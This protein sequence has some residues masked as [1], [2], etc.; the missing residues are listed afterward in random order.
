MDV[1][2]PEDTKNIMLH[3]NSLFGKPF[4]H[5]TRPKE[6]N[7]KLFSLIYDPQ[8]LCALKCFY[9]RLYP[10]NRKI[11]VLLVKLQEKI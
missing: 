11:P 6:L 5:N 9:F 1:K 7:P 3:V 4:C 10:V 8:I 2:T